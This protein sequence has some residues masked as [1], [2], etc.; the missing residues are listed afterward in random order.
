M[1]NAVTITP[2]LFERIRP[3][4]EFR[5]SAKHLFPTDDSLRWFLRTNGRALE[6]AGALLKL[7][8]GVYIDPEQ[9]KSV[10]LS[11]MQQ[12]A[13]SSTELARDVS[14]LLG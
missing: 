4:K 14:N 6:E 10:A 13:E 11:L 8:R 3:W 12:P 5:N 7:G 1:T 2:S 9:F